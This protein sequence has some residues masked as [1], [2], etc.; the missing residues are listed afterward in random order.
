M[1]DD[2][3]M[4]YDDYLISSDRNSDD[5]RQVLI[6]KGD[7]LDLPILSHYEINSLA[8]VV[9]GMMNWNKLG[10]GYVVSVGKWEDH[11]T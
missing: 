3:R 4:S 11:K 5:K 8:L 6:E 10:T 2:M 7:I 9:N 1:P